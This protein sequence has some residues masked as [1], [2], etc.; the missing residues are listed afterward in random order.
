MRLI[1]AS[2]Y[3][4]HPNNKV[5][6]CAR[7]VARLYEESNEHRGTQIVFSD[8]GTPKPD[9][10]NIYDALKDKLVS[11]FN[12][13]AHE[14]TFIHNWTDRQKPDLFR[15][16]NAGD[17]RILIGS[18]EKAGT[19][20]NVQ[21]RV[22]AM[23]HLDI[24]WKPSELEQRDGRGARQGNWLAKEFFGNKVKNFIYAVEMSLDNYKFGL[25]KNKQRF[26]SQMKNCEL[27]VRTIDEGAMDEQSG[28]NFSEY[29]A[30]L[31]GDTSLLE[32][33][34]LEKK[35]AELESYKTAHFKDVARSRYKL[36]DLEKKLAASKSTLEKLVLD[37]AHYKKELKY[38]TEGAKYNPIRI[39]GE[40]SAESAIIG[41]KIIDLYKNYQP[42]NKD[43]PEMQIGTLYGYDLYIKKEIGWI[44][45]ETAG[46][47]DF[48]TTLYAQSPA[49]GIKYM[50]NN[51]IPNIDNPKLTA[52]YFLSA[53]DRI[54][55]L[56]EKYSKQVAELEIEIP[57]VHELT[58][59]VF[60]RED[61]LA[62]MKRELTVLEEEITRKIKEKQLEPE[63]IEI[64]PDEPEDEDLSYHNGPK[65]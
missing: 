3:G 34:K 43:R 23:H 53:I 12:I 52:R 11:D 21:R 46:S 28:M 55:S 7:N 57:I 13:P 19:G 40:N 61:E 41:K 59:R 32:K 17:I 25:L 42:E 26:I 1:N 60:D 51:G 31:S 38:D 18:T 58:L 24:P 4:D 37:N 9:S 20:L 16:M 5:S 2:K 50:Q 62:G 8:I 6:I 33:T 45:T 29:I 44:E 35:V 15:R 56:N 10:F 63:S 14:I 39:N 27:S 48:Q 65:R 47:Y 64:F 22:V 30:I 54:G 49:T 36:E